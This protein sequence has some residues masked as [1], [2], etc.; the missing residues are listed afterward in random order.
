[1]QLEALCSIELVSKED[2]LA[3]AVQ[4]TRA[5]IVASTTRCRSVRPLVIILMNAS[6]L[7]RCNVF[8]QYILLKYFRK[9]VTYVASTRY[10]YLRIRCVRF[11]CDKISVPIHTVISLYL[12]CHNRSVSAFWSKIFVILC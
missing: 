2:I 7:C 1:V 3:C 11:T 10:V 6:Y 9:K 4:W 5:V 12:H 8:A